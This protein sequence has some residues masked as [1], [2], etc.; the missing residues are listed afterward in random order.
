MSQKGECESSAR[1]PL[2]SY[3]SLLRD[4]RPYRLLW[5]GLAV[6]MAGDWFRIIALYHL[7]LALTGAS[8]LALGGVLIAQS[9]SMFVT[10]PIAGVLADRLSRKAIMIGADIIRA[11]FSLGFLLITTADTVWL[12]YVLTAAIMAVSS[13]FSPALMAIIPN[14]TRRQELVTANALASSTWAA[15]LAIGSG[16]GGLVTAVLGTSVAF[17]ID[18][19]TYGLSALLI[20]SVVIPSPTEE[21]YYSVVEERSG[22]WLAFLQGLRYLQQEL[23]VRRLLS[24]KVWSAGVGGGII[25]L[26]TLFAENIF[27]AGAAGMGLVYMV[28][29]V[30]AVVGPVAAHRLVG[31]NPEAMIRMI[32]VSFLI[33]AVSYFLFAWMPTLL[34]ALMVLC[35]A[36]MAANILWVFSSTLLQLNVPDDYRGRVFGADFALLTIVMAVVTL[37]T[38]W[39][40]DHTS[41]GLRPV[42][43]ILAAVMIF[44]AVWWVWP[45]DRL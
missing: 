44:P 45:S 17:Y 33:L 2:V 34:G 32:G 3:W 11:V 36:S 35:I 14:L 12:A 7:V 28:R 22:S 38:G 18:A 40:V 4:N 29:G 10:S 16:L 30:G 20:A 43:S 13:F 26:S 42:M 24:I 1:E 39:A 19:A 27:Q 41:L 37:L 6:S 23:V 25:I 15:M 5:F 8:G 9:L 21:R 31:D